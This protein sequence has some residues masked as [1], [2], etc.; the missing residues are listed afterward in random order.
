VGFDDAA[1]ARVFDLVGGVPA[2]V[3]F[4]CQRA[5]AEARRSSTAT[6]D[7]SVVETV[8]RDLRLA[9]PSSTSGWLPILG[10]LTIF[11]L[12]VLAG[13]AVAA[14]VFRDEVAMLMGQ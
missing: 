2:A 14:L 9:P 12:F 5:L 10:T 7:E 3:N 8:A 11:V 13:A 1:A 6:V 4:L